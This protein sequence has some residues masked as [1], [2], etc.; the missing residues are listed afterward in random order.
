VNVLAKGLL[1]ANLAGAIRL[2]R[3]GPQDA[4]RRLAE[5]YAQI[6]PFGHSEEYGTPTSRCLADLASIPEVTLE[7]VIRGQPTIRVAGL[8]RHIEGTMPWCDISALLAIL[9]DRDPRVMLEIGTF[10]GHTTRLM[11]LNLP[12]A[13]VHT[14]DLPEDYDPQADRSSL[15]K[16]DPHL[17]ESRRVGAEYRADPSITNVVQ[18]FG[19]S[20]AWDF[21]IVAGATFYLID[22]AHTYEYARSDTEKALAAARGRDATLVWH[23]VDRW[24]PGVT[25]WLAEMVKKGYPVKRIGWTHL[26]LMDLT[27]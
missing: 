14:L 10:H 25:R 7:E 3:F 17:I 15:P 22:G 12:S 4:R 27:A 18:H 24:H 23:D 8:S 1:S 21:S 16:D 20:A 19:D 6:D 26:A 5:A 9:V 11:A 13:T 2:A